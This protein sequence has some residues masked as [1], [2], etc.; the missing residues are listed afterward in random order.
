VNDEGRD[1]ERDLSAQEREE[2]EER[3]AVA[4]DAEVGGD[5]TMRI[6]L[7]CHTSL[8]RDSGTPAV[9]ILDRCR[10]EGIDV[11]AITD[12]HHVSAAQR[13]REMVEEQGG[14]EA[15]GVTIIVGEEIWTSEGEL[16]ALFI[17]ERIEGNLS[18]EETVARIK[19]QGGLV[20]LPHGFDPR[21]RS[22]LRPGARERIADEIDIVETFNTHV[23]SPRWNERAVEWA[24]ARGLP[25]SA[26]SDAHKLDEIGSAWVEVPAR[27]IRGPEDLLAALEDGVP[28]GEWTNPLLDVLPRLWDRA[29]RFVQRVF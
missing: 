22:Q 19:E 5:R 2:L 6:D 11:Q 13:L 28:T 26:G 17:Q 10:E 8:S 16:V 15:V 23:S 24:R 9:L 12:H 21:K 18:P 3:G 29:K 27:P 20:L 14:P 4:P 7:H 25:M 1:L